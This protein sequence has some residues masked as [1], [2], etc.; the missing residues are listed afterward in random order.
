MASFLEEMKMP[1]Y[2]TYML[3]LTALLGVLGYSYI[4]AVLGKLMDI[5]GVG[6]PALDNQKCVVQITEERFDI[7]RWN[8]SAYMDRDMQNDSYYK[9]DFE[10]IAMDAM[11]KSLKQFVKV[12]YEDGVSSGRKRIKL[13][14]NLAIKR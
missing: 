10:A 4:V 2:E 5:P 14:I 13:S 9:K 7:Q 8:Y 6:Y 1:V 11:A 3:T 12:E